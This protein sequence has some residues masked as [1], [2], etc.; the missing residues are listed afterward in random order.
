[1]S[2]HDRA[3]VASLLGRDAEQLAAHLGIE[4]RS[5]K[6]HSGQAQAVIDQIS[7]VEMAKD[8]GFLMFKITG[9][10]E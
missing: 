1:M 6:E 10:R 4:S 5:S 3:H 9:F 8:A 7:R 2:P